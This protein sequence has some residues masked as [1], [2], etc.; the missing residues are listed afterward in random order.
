[1]SFDSIIS[2]NNIII[3]YIRI[4]NTYNFSHSVNVYIQ[5]MQIV[6]FQSL[7]FIR[8]FFILISRINI[9]LAINQ[10]ILTDFSVNFIVLL[11]LW[12]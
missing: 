2:L 8:I 9:I 10:S 6:K 11:I 3:I 1:M 5:R 4:E 7:D 12:L